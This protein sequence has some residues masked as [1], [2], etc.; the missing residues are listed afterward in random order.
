V[1]DAYDAHLE[2]MSLTGDRGTPT[3]DT[4]VPAPDLWIDDD[5][6]TERNEE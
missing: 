5:E 2:Y 4:Q 3:G 6:D 1:L